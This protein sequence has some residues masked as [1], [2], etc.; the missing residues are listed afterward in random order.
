M[1]DREI[2][3]LFRKRSE[4]ALSETEKK[5]GR[6][7]L[8][9]A[10]RILGSAA[11]AEEI[12]NDAYLKAWNTIPPQDPESLKSYLGMLCRQLALDRYERDHA[13][14]RG[15]QT[16]LVLDE[17]E[18]VLPDE[19]GGSDPAESAALTAA[20]DAFLA[21]LPDRTRKVFLRR[22]WY[23]AP[24]SEIAAEYGMRESGVT[25]LLLR[26]RKKLKDFLEKEGFS[27]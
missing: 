9:I 17:L 24:I 11:D 7:C 8:Y 27:L 4:A 20:M 1:E 14:K 5:Y 18:E 3:E 22:Y 12:V 21:S 13:A 6:Y 15:G 10:E 23:A 2:K 16:A 26:T 19:N 25:V